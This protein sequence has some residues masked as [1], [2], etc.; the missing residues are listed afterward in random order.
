L[1]TVALDCEPC[2]L[3]AEELPELIEQEWAPL[4][5]RAVTLVLGDV[6]DAAQWRDTYGLDASAVVADPDASMM[7]GIPVTPLH[8]VV[9]PRT[10]AVEHRREGFVSPYTELLDLAED[11]AAQVP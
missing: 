7:K 3:E 2:R 1:I 4:G 11:N 8:V 9:D 10:L 6:E 5:I